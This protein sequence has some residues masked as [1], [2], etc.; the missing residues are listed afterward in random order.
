MER[1]ALGMPDNRLRRLHLQKRFLQTISLCLFAL[2]SHAAESHSYGNLPL[3]FEA[4][5]YASHVKFLSHG[6]NYGLSLTVDEAVINF[7]D[8]ATLRMKLIG[9]NR[10]L[11]IVGQD[12]LAGKSNYFLGN[13]P[14]KWRT[15]VSN[16]AKVKYTGIYPGID[17]VFYG[18]QKQLEYDF[19]VAPG[20]DAAAI[21]LAFTPSPDARVD[22]NGDLILH[23]AGHEVRWL[24]PII[25]QEQHGFRR[26][27]AGGF[28]RH[29]G[30]LIGF[31][32]GKYDHARPLIIDPTLSTVFSTYLGGAQQDSAPAIAVDAAGNTYVAGW[33]L[34]TDFPSRSWI[35]GCVC[36]QVQCVRL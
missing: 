36:R 26:E 22:L 5:G 35:G 3:S 21:R 24:R 27:I 2:I 12:E 13:D 30:N 15:N 1:V 23:L 31:Q 34:S 18:N 29:A 14:S 9:A 28:A 4:A 11:R 20:A 16:Y 8:S 33:T 32:V 19:M 10:E 17:L 6:T 25:Y 7:Q